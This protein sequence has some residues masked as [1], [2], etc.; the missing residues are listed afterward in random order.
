MIHKINYLTSIGR[1]RKYVAAGQ[2]D[3]KKMTLIYGDNGGG[4]TTLTSV[5]RSL[6]INNP[7]LVLRRKST[8]S[9]VNQAAQI[10]YRNETDSTHTFHHTNGWTIPRANIEIFDIHFVQDNIYSGYQ[11]TDNHQKGLHQFVVGAQG[12]AIQQQLDENKANKTRITITVNELLAQLYESVGNG[13]N[14]ENVKE[15]TKIPESDAE[16]ISERILIAERNLIN[17]TTNHIIQTLQ[18]LNEVVRTSSGIDFDSLIVDLTSTTEVIQQEALQ[19]LFVGHCEE[20]RQNTIAS[21]ENWLQ[22]GF[23]YLQSK[24]L[25][26]GE[27]IDVSCPFCKQNIDNSLDIIK[28]YILKFNEQFNF[29]VNRIKSQIE[30]IEAFNIEAA[31]QRVNSVIEANTSKIA[32][33][34]TYLPNTVIAPTF[35]LTDYNTF[36][37]QYNSLLALVKQKLQNPSIAVSTNP[38]SDFRSTGQSINN[39]ILLYNQSVVVYNIAITTFRAGILTVQNAQNELYK[40]KRIQKRFEPEIVTICSSLATES[41]NFNVLK[42]AY[43]LLIAQQEAENRT[44]FTSYKERI[45]Y[46]LTDIFKT[47]FKI[48]DVQHIP[49]SGRAT[50]NK[51]GYKL[52]IDGN[53]I[54][55]D[56]TDLLS[57]KECFSEGDKSTIALAF[58]LSKL[59]IDPNKTDKILVFDDPLS[60]FDTNRRSY[61]VN[62][63]QNLY[64]EIKQVIVLSH[65]PYFL[66]EISSRVLA[67]DI[68]TLQ[69]KQNFTAKESKIEPCDLEELIKNDYFRQMDELEK[70]QASP[71]LLLKDNVL[72]WLR[73]VLETHLKFKFYREIKNFNGTKTFNNL[74]RHLNTSTV[75]F[76][77]NVNRAEI[78]NKLTL[79]DNISWRPHHGEPMPE[80]NSMTYNPQ[81]IT[82]TELNNLITDTLDLINRQL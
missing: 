28:A 17:A 76:S 1:Y 80:A 48:E 19:N 31:E 23:N 38:I 75:V 36:K 61:T 52:T 8:N 11:I 32:S 25:N 2:V 12:I 33:W 64:R 55:F 9:T 27:N 53:D 37:E 34:T 21:P 54:S 63:I 79:I 71:D 41:A 30:N 35:P 44:F 66:H 56:S 26:I 46:Y 39:S 40:L 59:D 70:F 77:D 74:I 49:P 24:P 3:F 7:S 10:V 13:L 57:T 20:L 29:L 67:N 45:N 43:P 68:K 42:T 5:L 82:E 15:F 14:K 72:G 6:A 22:I 18:P 62:I 4:K 69:I 16:N 58:F 51:L 65:N 60:S 81:T 73:T 78:I 47:L 50:G